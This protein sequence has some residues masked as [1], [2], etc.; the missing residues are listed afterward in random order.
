M[1]PSNLGLGLL[2]T[3]DDKASKP[4]AGLTR[5]M[6]GLGK[7]SEKTSRMMDRG[8]KQIRKAGSSI[9]GSLFGRKG[10]RGAGGRFQA[11]DQ[12]I[13]GRQVSRIRSFGRD[14]G[15]REFLLGRKG[16]RDARGKFLKDKQGIIGRGLGAISSPFRGRGGGAGG[17]TQQDLIGGAGLGAGAIA[18]GASLNK[19]VNM[20]ADFEFGLAE[21]K[22][23]AGA[24][25]K[26]MNILRDAAFE[27]GLKTQFSPTQAVEGLRNFAAAGFKAT[28]SAKLLDRAL[29]LAQ[30]GQISVA[31]STAA[32]STAIKLFNLQGKDQTLLV[33]KLL[34]T[35]NLF[36]IQASD[37][38]QGIAK[39]AAAALLTNQSVDEMLLTV[40]LIK[41]VFPDAGEA[42]NSVSRAMQS[43][44]QKGDKVKKTFGVDVLD[45]EGAF[46]PALDLF[47]E[48]DEASKKAIPNTAKRAKE[49]SKL[50]GAFGVKGFAA[51]TGSIKTFATEND[52]TL[53]EAA[54]QLR[55]SIAGAEGTADE[56]LAGLNATFKGQK[57]ILQGAIETLAVAVGEPLLRVLQPAVKT[58][59]E[60]VSN[61]ARAIKNADPVFKDTLGRIAFIHLTKDFGEP[62]WKSR[63]LERL[64]DIVFSGPPLKLDDTA[65]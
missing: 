2:L 6:R 61:L 32:M 64:H 31:Q 3:A 11:A 35:T 30:A 39:T 45:A 46:K 12:G 19:V 22:N 49:L 53:K 5:N 17:A 26:E 24:T 63:I 58:A 55:G 56:F 59:A 48:I 25:A 16:K 15:A 14:G 47:L 36:K 9:R 1:P 57:I 27:A 60:L 13:F 20:A 10:G 51:A 38:E 43:L 18:V 37:L 54:K 28:Q 8:F 34:K 23:I 65:C 41:N 4:V 42:G 33:D 52:L 21:V 7:Q 44:A 29:I 50:F 40:G 62:R